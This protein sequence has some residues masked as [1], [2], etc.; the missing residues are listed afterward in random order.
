MHY[1]FQSRLLLKLKCT[2]TSKVC[3][4]LKNPF[5]W[6]QNCWCSTVCTIL[7]QLIL[8]FLPCRSTSVALFIGSF[9]SFQLDGFLDF[10]IFSVCSIY[11]ALTWM[12]GK[13]L[14]SV[15]P[16]SFPQS[17]CCILPQ[18]DNCCNFVGSVLHKFLKVG[19]QELW[20]SD[21]FVYT[22]ENWHIF[23]WW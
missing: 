14:Y 1:K 3:K 7:M 16:S 8:C 21:S 2:S 19:W 22:L 12:G 6:H 9:F 11:Q 13:P 18:G 23:G 5:S 15:S 20:Y 10:N 4:T 17:Y